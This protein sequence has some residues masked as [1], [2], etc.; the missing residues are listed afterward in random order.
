MDVYTKI[1]QL[2]ED[3]YSQRDIAKMLGVSRNT[4]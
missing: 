4:V 3:N 2:K 1:K